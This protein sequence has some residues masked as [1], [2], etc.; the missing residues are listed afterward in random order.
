MPSDRL[1]RVLTKLHDGKSG[2]DVAPERFC[3]VS[4]SIAGA[5]GAGIMILSDSYQHGALCHSD[6]MSALIDELQFTLGEGPGL[7]AF[8]RTRPILEPDLIAPKTIR[9]TAFT[10][11]AVAAGARAIFGFPLQVGDLRVGAL[12]LYR[13]E[14]GGLDV[15]QHADTLVMAGVAARA[16]LA[17]QVDSALDVIEPKLEI[18]SKLRLVVHQASGMVASQLHI[19]VA[20]ALERLRAYAFANALS[21]DDTARNVMARRIRFDMDEKPER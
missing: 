13:I 20:D 2:T 11:S 18:Q 12:N 21:L 19:P 4:A 8:S 17:M 10:Q 14:P 6:A 5:T 1:L 9:W 7:D 16:V 3:E 15:D